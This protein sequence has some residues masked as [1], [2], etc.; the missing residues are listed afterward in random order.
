MQKEYKIRDFIKKYLFWILVSPILLI[1]LL[2][3]IVRLGTSI[4]NTNELTID[5][6]SPVKLGEYLFY[7]ISVVGIEVTGLLSAAIW[8]T[9][10]ESN[11]LWEDISNKEENKDKEVIRES[12]LI[13]YYDLISNI[14][15]LKM[16]Y[17]AQ[18]LKTKTVET[19]RLNI[20]PDWVK[21]IANLRDIL[22]GKELEMIFTLY[23]SFLL[24]SELERDSNVESNELKTLVNK[25]AK[26][27]FIPVLLDNLWMDF[28]GVTESILN[29]KY[30]PILRKIQLAS[31]ISLSDNEYNYFNE[32]GEL[33]V[34]QN[35][36]SIKYKGEF[37][38]G[39]IQNGIDEWHL[40]D[41]T[42]F[43][44]FQ[45]E[46]GEIIK[47]N[48]SNKFRNKYEL[49]FDCQFN[50]E[51]KQ[52]DGYTTTFYS[53]NMIKYQ[54]SIV[55]GKYYGEGKSYADK[56]S[57]KL[58]FS[59]TWEKG[60]MLSGRYIN[61]SSN[62]IVYFKGEYKNKLP[63][64]G[65]IECSEFYEFNGTYGFK[66]RIDKGRPIE[67]SGYKFVREIVDK[68]Y[69]DESSFADMEENTFDDYDDQ[70]EN[71][72]DEVIQELNE[73]NERDK[74]QGMF[75]ELKQNYGRVVEL[76]RADWT[77]GD[78]KVYEDDI[79][80]KKHLAYSSSKKN[81]E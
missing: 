73:N 16:L 19:N 74:R 66:G 58:L 71:L 22:T 33:C 77:N 44:S 30:Y 35:N 55:A 81:I 47:G 61:K 13:V 62:R 23:N 42:L 75:D 52:T 20:L 72:P 46:N 3:I 38:N 37:I 39:I 48:Y 54:G 63:Y 12:A 59:G 6:D 5:L 21:N 53:A 50:Q 15:I 76:I 29:N 67:G 1:S 45:Y 17:S 31:K 27:I 51:G 68:E 69:I 57:S 28:N 64:T 9:S 11:K 56:N 4:I 70:Y 49:I 2:S 8:K 79:I 65:T 34:K 24:L 80:N 36:G 14:S 41:G 7:Y 40:D 43:Y 60:K 25:L 32:E 10:M 78:S 18:M 26:K